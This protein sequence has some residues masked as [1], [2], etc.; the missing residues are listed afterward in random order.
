MRGFTLRRIMI[1]VALIGLLATLVG[2][3]VV[4]G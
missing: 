2:P 3:H 4:C 1:V